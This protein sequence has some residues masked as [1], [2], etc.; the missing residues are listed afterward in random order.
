MDMSLGKLREIVKDREA[1]CPASIGS[2]RV[3]HDLVTEQQKMVWR[4]EEREQERK[5]RRETQGHRE[6]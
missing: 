6:F 1:W 3:G 2:R 5:G 4:K